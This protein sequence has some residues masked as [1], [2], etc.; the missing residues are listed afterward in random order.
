MMDNAGQRERLLPQHDGITQAEGVG[1]ALLPLLM[2]EHAP[3]NGRD[4]V[5]ES[6]GQASRPS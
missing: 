6:A 3:W 1:L 4:A 5:K 2:I